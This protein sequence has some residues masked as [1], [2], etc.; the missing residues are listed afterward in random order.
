MVREVR[1]TGEG[2]AELTA[3]EILSDELI[4]IEDDTDRLMK[5][6]M[7]L[8]FRGLRKKEGRHQK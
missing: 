1:S 5:V 2:A 3:D 4:D 8:K 6:K 7:K